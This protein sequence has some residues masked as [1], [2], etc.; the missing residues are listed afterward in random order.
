MTNLLLTSRLDA[1]RG[2]ILAACQAANR[3]DDAVTLLA[4]SKTKP[5]TDLVTAYQAGQRHFAEN[6]AQEAV[7]KCQ[8]AP[9]SDA[10]WHFIGPLQSNKTRAIA[11]HYDWVHTI[12]RLKIAQR[13]SAQRPADLP[14]LNVLI[15]VNISADPAKAGVKFDQV[16][17]LAEQINELPQLVFRGLMAI[18][19]ADLAESTLRAQYQQLK[20]LQNTLISRFPSCTEVS[21]GMSNDFAIAI[22]AGA[23]MVRIGS[24]IFGRREAR[25]TT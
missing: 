23:T 8:Q 15:Q 20:T 7:E 5:L 10:I 17:T 13:L 11:E 21:I 14:P 25:A 22:A 4:V 16:E 2:Q 3:P 1:V 24:D 19:A 6:Y 9:F 18:P 12:D